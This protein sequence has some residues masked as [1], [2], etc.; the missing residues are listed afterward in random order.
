MTRPPGELRLLLVDDDPAVVRAYQRILARHGVTVTTASDG[1]EAAE[2]V[3]GGEFD[4]IITDI[5]MP[6]MTGIEFLGVSA[7]LT[8]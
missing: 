5:S 7:K 1:R 6:E 8:A 4:V 2:R 3:R